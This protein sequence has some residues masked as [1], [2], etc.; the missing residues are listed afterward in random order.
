M[1]H[2]N[3]LSDKRQAVLNEDDSL[4]RFGTVAFSLALM[5]D[6]ILDETKLYGHLQPGAVLCGDW[7]SMVPDAYKAQV[8]T[9]IEPVIREYVYS[10]LLTDATVCSLIA[11]MNSEL[12]RKL[13]PIAP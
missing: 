1:V 11:D 9:I 8:M 6:L 3:F 4:R 13:R 10:Q 2:F 5:R 7:W 12:A